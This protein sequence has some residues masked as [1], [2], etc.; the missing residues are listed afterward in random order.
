MKKMEGSRKTRGADEGLGDRV[1]K[2]K[3]I[4]T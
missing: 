3:A 4:A 2:V 1:R